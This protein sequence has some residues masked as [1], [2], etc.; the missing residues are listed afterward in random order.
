MTDQTEA[1]IAAEHRLG[2]HN[3]D[4]IDVIL[5]KARQI[6]KETGVRVPMPDTDGSLTKALMAKVML[7]AKERRQYSLDL[8]PET[9]DLM[10]CPRGRLPRT[11]KRSLGGLGKSP[12]SETTCDDESAFGDRGP[13]D[14]VPLRR[15]GACWD[16]CSR[17]YP[18]MRSRW[19]TNC[20][21]IRCANGSMRE[22]FC[23]THG[24]CRECSLW[25]RLVLP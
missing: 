12:E 1:Y 9:S 6:E 19:C 7:S 25:Q 14:D 17:S 21:S 13:V 11:G 2:A 18:W 4:P 5:R 3:Y 22:A 23:T 24:S 16:C 15:T 10:S 8:L 20:R